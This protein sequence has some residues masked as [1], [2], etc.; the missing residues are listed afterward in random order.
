MKVYIASSWRN[1]EYEKVKD[2]FT[3][4]GYEVLDW[5]GPEGFS[6]S[7]VDPEWKTWTKE[8][9]IEALDHEEAQ[10]GFL[11]GAFCPTR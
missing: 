10:K 6:W 2:A 5:R 7:K 11:S 1:T 3:K 8:Q 4:I 9:Q